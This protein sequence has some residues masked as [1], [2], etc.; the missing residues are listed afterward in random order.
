VLPGVVAA[1]GSKMGGANEPTADGAPASPVHA[2]DAAALT[3]LDECVDGDDAVETPLSKGVDLGQQLAVEV[4]SCV[5]VVCVV[6]RILDAVLV[7]R[8]L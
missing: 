3:M 8:P 6:G 4:W 5:V 1:Y 7:R 2:P